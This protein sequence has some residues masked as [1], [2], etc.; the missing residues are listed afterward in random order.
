MMRTHKV[1]GTRLKAPKVS[2]PLDF[3]AKV[4]GQVIEF[5][6]TREELEDNCDRVEDIAN[7]FYTLLA[8][9]AGI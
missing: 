9:E 4:E 8:D 7:Y 1:P 2:T 3:F 6:V 5:T